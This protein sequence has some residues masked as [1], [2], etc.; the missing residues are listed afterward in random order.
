DLAGGAVSA[1]VPIMSEECL[2]HRM[3]CVRCAQTLNG[4]DLLTIMHQSQAETRVHTPAIDMH[5]AGAALAVITAF[6]RAGEGDGLANT[7]QQR[8]ARIDS[9]V[10][11]FAVNP[12]RDWDSS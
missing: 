8:R 10:V 7:I 6:L 3:Q 12:Q 9:K 11:V 5:R 4:R 2:L 1:L